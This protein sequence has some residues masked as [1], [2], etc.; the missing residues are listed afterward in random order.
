M[1]SKPRHVPKALAFA[2][3]LLPVCLV[4]GMTSPNLRA[5]GPDRVDIAVTYI[6]LQATHTVNTGSL[7]LQGGAVEVHAPLFR[8]LGAVA[9]VT[10]LHLGSDSPAVAPLDLVTVVMGARYAFLR[11]HRISPYVQGLVGEADGFHSV[12]A[13]GSGPVN[14]VNGTTDSANSIAI[15]A[16]GGVDFRLSRQLSVRAIEA[17]Y[18]HTQ[19]PNGGNNSQNNLR[20]AAGL[21]YRFGR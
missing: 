9:N 17:D 19:L 8:G 14:A 6:A 13:T 10:G 7:W 1:Q 18:L 4:L 11:R 16:G 21:V 15:Q 5:Q 12:F 2:A 20:L 3:K